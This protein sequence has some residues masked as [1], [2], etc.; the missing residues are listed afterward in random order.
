MNIERQDNKRVLALLCLLG[1]AL[2]TWVGKQF[3][4]LPSRTTVL[5]TKVQSWEARQDRMDDKLDKI[6]SAV[7]R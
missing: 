6:L 3:A 7:V 2:L 5:E 4:E 1:A